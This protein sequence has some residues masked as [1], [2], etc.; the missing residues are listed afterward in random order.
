MWITPKPNG[1]ATLTCCSSLAG[2]RSFHCAHLQPNVRA[3][4]PAGRRTA[5]SRAPKCSQSAGRKWR[6]AARLDDWRTSGKRRS[7]GAAG[8]LPF[9]VPSGRRSGG[10]QRPAARQW[11]AHT[12]S[13][14][15]AAA[16]RG[17][18]AAGWRAH[19]AGTGG[20]PLVVGAAGGARGQAHLRPQ[21]ASGRARSHRPPAAA[22]P[23]KNE[24]ARGAAGR[25][26]C[27]ANS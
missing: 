4:L 7:S 25:R 8:L 20:R 11:C 26:R 19:T 17:A 24:P 23:W 6:P 9:G 22:R 16:A 1:R 3:R 15:A 13:S 14:S 12:S 2:A 18:A 10:Q 21:T 27:A 5:S